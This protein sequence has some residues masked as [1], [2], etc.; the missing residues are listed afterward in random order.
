MKQKLLEIIEYLK[1]NNV[2]YADIRYVFTRAES[3]S[4]RNQLVENITGDESIGFGVRVIYKG[5]WGFASSSIVNLPSMKKAARM[6]I[7][8][9]RAS[10]TTINK[11]AKLTEAEP[12]IDTYRTPYKEDPFEVPMD[13]KLNLLITTTQ[14][15][16]TD[17]LIKSAEASLN[18]WK[19]HKIFAS[20]EGAYIEQDILESGGG[21]KATAV[22]SNDVQWRSYPNSHRGDF[23]TGGYEFIR[24]LDFLSHT[25][26]VKEEAVALLKASPCPSTEATIIIGGSQMALQIHESCGHPAELDRV[27]GTELSFAGGSFLTIDKLG[28]FR[29]GSPIVNIVQDATAERG[30]GSFGYD[31]EGIKAQRTDVIREGI[32]T[33]YLTSRETAPVIGQ[34]SNGCM[35][36]DGYNRIPLIRMTNINLE[37]GEGSLE[38]LISDTKNGYYFDMNKSWSIDDKR[39][40]FQFGVEAAWEIK[41]GKLRRMLKNPVYTGITPEFW[42]SCDAIAGKSEWH[43]WGV[44]N[45]GKGEPTQTARVAHGTSPARFH[46]VKIGVS[47]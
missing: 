5:A 9:A 10:A 20:T 22:G 18:F 29:Y 32:F 37:P 4:V 7:E 42:N 27:L 45:C 17:K 3:I 44:P 36:A 8:I 41:N 34:K 24:E 15:M 26:R 14:E 31:D 39:L 47:K 6:A 2:D 21:F 1:K 23:I 33:G 25:D 16:K 11:K 40:N 13:D 43:I 28:S 30:L 19:T 35:R 46:N 12:Y 38:E